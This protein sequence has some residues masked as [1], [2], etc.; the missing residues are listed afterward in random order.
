V[1]QPDR[2]IYEVIQLVLAKYGFVR[3]A[4]QWFRD[5]D[6]E[7]PAG[8]T[9]GTRLGWQVLLQSLIRN[10]QRNPLCSESCLRARHPVE[11]HNAKIT[12][13]EIFYPF[14]RFHTSIL[15][16][17]EKLK[18]RDNAVSAINPIARRLQVPLWMRLPDSTE[19]KIAALLGLGRGV[20]K[21]LSPDVVSA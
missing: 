13:A 20:Q 1:F 8:P 7:L 2:R 12:H 5:H 14:H 16:V 17:I 19:M 4:V 21:S 15:G 6:V 9:H 11:A 3:Q 18:R 10:A